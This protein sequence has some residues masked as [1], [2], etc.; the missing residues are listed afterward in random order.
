MSRRILG[1][2]TTNWG[3]ISNSRSSKGSRKFNPKSGDYD[4]RID[5]LDASGKTN[6]T[7][8]VKADHI[9]EVQSY[10]FRNIEYGQQ[11]KIDGQEFTK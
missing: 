8:N 10:A 1:M 5:Y 9:D 6:K 7:E 4:W 11:I 3:A 2:R